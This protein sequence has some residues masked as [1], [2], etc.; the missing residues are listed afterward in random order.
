MNV[1][2]SFLVDYS[3]RL[4]LNTKADAGQIPEMQ[5]E[6]KSLVGEN[7]G[8]WDI[9]VILKGSEICDGN[10]Q[11]SYQIKTLPTEIVV[12]FFRSDNSRQQEEH[13]NI[14]DLLTK[15]NSLAS[16]VNELILCKLGK[17]DAKLSIELAQ[18]V[19]YVGLTKLP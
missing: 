4:V 8:D 6:I 16:N 19:D 15:Q 7:K 3:N 12:G 2:H 10:K 9:T 1:T 14:T 13:C 18:E 11:K 17:N 5:I